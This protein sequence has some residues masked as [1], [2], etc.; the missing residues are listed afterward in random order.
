MRRPGNGEVC[1]I[2]HSKKIINPNRLNSTSDQ[3]DASRFSLTVKKGRG[4]ESVVE[5]R[6]MIFA[7]SCVL[8][9]HFG[10]AVRN[11]KGVRKVLDIGKLSW[12]LDRERDNM[13]FEIK[14]LANVFASVWSP[15]THEEAYGLCEVAETPLFDIGGVVKERL[16]ESTRVATPQISSGIGSV[17][18]VYTGRVSVVVPIDRNELESIY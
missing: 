8:A 3:R 9:R 4:M 18:R 6:T 1:G 5:K 15:G 17:P 12:S 13:V 14:L 16:D 2:Y 7:R 11:A 10:E